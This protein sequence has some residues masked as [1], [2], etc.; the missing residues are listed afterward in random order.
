MFCL[1][2]SILSLALNSSVQDFQEDDQLR[3]SLS[4]F[5]DIVLEDCLRLSLSEALTI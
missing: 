1:S 5:I 4:F 2:L 3:F